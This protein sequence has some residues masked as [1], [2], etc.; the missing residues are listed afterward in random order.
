MTLEQAIEVVAQG[1]LYARS[2][3][4]TELVVNTNGLTG[5]P[6][7]STFGRYALAVR[8]AECG[9]GVLRLAVVTNAERIDHQKI[10]VIM[11]RNRGLDLDAF[12]SEEDAVSWLDSRASRP[13]ESHARA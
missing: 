3:G 13:R 12:T 8:W 1:M 11:G 9:A 5:Y 4:L 10:G 2:I 7:P 6:R